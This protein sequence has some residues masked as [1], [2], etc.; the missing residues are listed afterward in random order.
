[1]EITKPTKRV[2]KYYAGIGS[3]SAPK[4]ILLI[5]KKLATKLSQ[6]DWICRSGGA[7]G[8]DTAFQEG[9]SKFEVYY[10]DK[11]VLTENGSIDKVKDSKWKEASQMSQL[12][13]PAWKNLKPY[14]K[15]LHTRN[16]FQLIGLNSIA[17]KFVVCWTPDGAETTEKTSRE[18]GGTGQAIR[19]ANSLQIPVFN[20]GNI[21]TLERITL[22]IE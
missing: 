19:I 7:T 22:W 12:Y 13:H 6:E 8:C 18:T 17:S 20:L 10:P 5:C 11:I 9:S 15:N 4:E 21:V 16:S 2:N 14:V 1:M 3:R